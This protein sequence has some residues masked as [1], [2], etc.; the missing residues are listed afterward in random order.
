MRIR[1]NNYKGHCIHSREAKRNAGLPAGIALLPQAKAVNA[2]FATL[3]KLFKCLVSANP[4][5]QEAGVTL[6]LTAMVF[7]PFQVNDL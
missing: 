7:S 1:N 6:I 2:T 4:T 5:G 3:A